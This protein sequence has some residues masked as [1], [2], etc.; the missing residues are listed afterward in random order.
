LLLT[1]PV[2]SL[3]SLLMIYKSFPKRVLLFVAGSVVILGI[4]SGIAG[5]YVL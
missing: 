1:L 5:M 2:V 3:P 4:L